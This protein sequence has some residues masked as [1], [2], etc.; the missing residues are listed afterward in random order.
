MSSQADNDE[1]DENGLP[2]PQFPPHGDKPRVWF[3]TAADSPIGIALVRHLLEHGDNVVAAISSTQFAKA[4]TYF[5]DF[6]QLINEIHSN[7]DW[8]KAFHEVPLNSKLIADCQAAIATAVRVFGRVDILFCC[9]SEALFGTVEE[10]AQSSIVHSAV[11]SQFQT[12][13]FGPVNIIKSALPTLRAQRSGHIVMLTGITGHLGTP[14][15]SVYCAS[16]W[17]IEG[18][19]DS[20]AY[21]VAPFDIKVSIVQSSIEVSV[22]TNPIVAAPPM[23]EYGSEKHGAPLARRIFARLLDSLDQSTAPRD[24][25]DGGSSTLPEEMQR[26]RLENELLNND[27]LTQIRAP[28]P[29]SFRDQ[30]LA[31]TVHAV[32][33]IGGHSTP[34]A[35]H[36][37]GHEGVA[38][39][40]EKLLT[41]GQEL[42]EFVE[43]SAAADLPEAARMQ[44]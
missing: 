16:Q 40:K 38:S 37:V 18:Y 12:I 42:E 36:I 9:Q 5:P 10:L 11:Q 44:S 2:T 22:L 19:V 13:F 24:T 1:L 31:E 26:M 33:A 14:G 43:V 39:V 7:D 20:L 34:P 35:R 6:A 15:L 29:T 30:L 27:T 25:E 23:P 8:N 32:L 21:E 41:A 3:L 28:L 4:D 17:A